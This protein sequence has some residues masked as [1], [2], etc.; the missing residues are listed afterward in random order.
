MPYQI[1]QKVEVTV[2]RTPGT[3]IADSRVGEVIGMTE[4]EVT[5]KL[6]DGQKKTLAYDSVSPLSMAV[7]DEHPGNAGLRQVLE[8]LLSSAKE[9]RDMKVE[10]NRDYSAED[11]AIWATTLQLAEKVIEL[12]CKSG[13]D[14]A[15]V[16][17]AKQLLLQG[18]EAQDAEKISCKCD[19][20]GHVCDISDLNDA[21]HLDQRLEYPPGHPKCIM[22]AGE[23]PECGCLSYAIDS[24]RKVS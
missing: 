21:E 20:C 15:I 3:M 1:H 2:A 14:P 9:L 5:V 13:V 11:L 8:G 16:Q 6:S 19:N 12:L 17:K 22:P 4:D 10:I 18:M 7:Q 23:C 24:G